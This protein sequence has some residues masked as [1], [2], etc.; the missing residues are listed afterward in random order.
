[1]GARAWIAPW[2]HPVEGVGLVVL[3]VMLK[4]LARWMGFCCARTLWHGRGW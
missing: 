1:M 2:A 4:M 3:G